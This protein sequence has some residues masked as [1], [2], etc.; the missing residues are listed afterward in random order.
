[1]SSEGFL[2]LRKKRR[3]MFSEGNVANL[4]RCDSPMQKILAIWRPF[5]E[6]E[7]SGLGVAARY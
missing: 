6:L 4:V 7:L 2:C 1:M 5:F 3:D